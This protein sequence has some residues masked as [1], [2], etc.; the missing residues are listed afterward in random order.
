MNQE[1]KEN[2]LD[3][4]VLFTDTDISILKEAI[5][6]TICNYDPSEQS[7]YQPA[8]YN[9]NQD[10]SLVAK[11]IALA[12]IGSLGMEGIDTYKQEGGLLFLEENPDFIPLVLKQEITNLAVDNPELY[13]NIRQ[14]LLKRAGFHVNFAKSRLK[15]FPQEIASFPP[16]TIP[17]L[18]SEIFRYLNIETIE[19]IELTT[20]TDEKTPLSKLIAFFQSGAVN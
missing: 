14:R 20:P 16:A 2:S 17:I 12:D 8:L 3:E 11:I 4:S 9:K 7:I 13:E 1:L 18:T 15:R 19:K 10:I 6:A 5:Q